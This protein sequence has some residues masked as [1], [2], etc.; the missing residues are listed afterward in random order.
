MHS[1]SNSLRNHAFVGLGGAL[2]GAIAMPLIQNLVKTI[3]P[4]LASGLAAFWNSLT[5]GGITVMVGECGIING[6][7]NQDITIY[8]DEVN[9][10]EA[11][12]L[13]VE[14]DLIY[15]WNQAISNSLNLDVNAVSTV[16]N[17]SITLYFVS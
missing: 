17:S 8:C 1:N 15:E 16:S 3:L 12:T 5:G 2:G 6:D 11:L 14:G 13:A 10:S 7:N 9:I 4:A